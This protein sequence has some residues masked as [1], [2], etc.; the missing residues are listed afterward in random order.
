MP[1]S[2]SQAVATIVW[3]SSDGSPSSSPY[4]HISS[5]PRRAVVGAVAER[6]HDPVDPVAES[7]QQ[8]PV[9]ADRHRLER[10]TGQRVHILGQRGTAYR[11]S[12]GHAVE[13]LVH[14]PVN[15]LRRHHA[16]H[17]DRRGLQWLCS[18]F[19]RPAANPAADGGPDGPGR[20]DEEGS[21]MTQT[22][23]ELVGKVV[24]D[25]AATFTGALVRLG[26]ELGLWR[27]LAEGGPATPADLAGRT[28]VGERYAAEWLPGVAAAGY[29]EYDA[30]TG[31]YALSE[32]QATVFA[33]D[34]SPVFLT[35]LYQVISA[36]Y[37][38]LP[39]LAARWRG[40]AGFGWHEHFRRRVHRH[41]A[42][43]PARLRR[44]PAGRLAAGAGRRRRQARRGRAGGRRRLRARHV[45]RGDRRGVPGRAAGRVRLPRG[46]DRR[47]PPRSPRR[48]GWTTG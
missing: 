43:L 9:G 17:G 37:A 1:A 27:A 15:H 23:D 5:D 38:D 35:G 24:A 44:T 28:G 8:V 40:G 33:D 34:R 36:V 2:G 20:P 25:A 29:V 30:A 3:S 42:V 47:A 32:A 13:H 22:I 19:R 4:S 16:P 10:R 12:T 45:D 48:P 41:R 18:G 11:P 21:D 39:A 7:L 14:R 6:P 46:L 26:D 31:Q